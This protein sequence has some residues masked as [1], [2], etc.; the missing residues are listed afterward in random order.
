MNSAEH[1]QFAAAVA[2]AN[3]LM[4][5]VQLT[6]ETHWLDEPYRPHRPGGMGDNDSGGLPEHLQI[7]VRDAALEAIV[8][9]RD[10]RPVALPEPDPDLLVR[11][12]S[13]AMDEHVPNE[14]GTMTAAQLGTIPMMIDEEIDVP[15]G[16]EVLIVGAGVSGI[17]AGVNLRRAG[18]P[19][20]IIEK[21]EAVG[22][23]WLEN[24]YPGAG[25]DTP[26]HLYSY[27]FAPYDFSKYFALREELHGYLEH[28]TDQDRIPR[29]VE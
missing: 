24:Q 20:T 18:V 19:F 16:F 28:V 5:L 3:L 12:L 6:G 27:S 14:Y 8:S 2:A 26:N 4:V 7:E 1:D 25:V 9:W 21:R 17:C 10:G 11:M 13:V 29:H 23:V 22:G 15:E